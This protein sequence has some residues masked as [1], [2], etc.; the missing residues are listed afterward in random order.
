MNQMR[1]S[2]GGRQSLASCINAYVTERHVLDVFQTEGRP[3]VVPENRSHPDAELRGK[4]CIVLR[5]GK[6]ST[7]ICKSSRERSR[8]APSET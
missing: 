4:M 2:T 1:S 3:Q 5:R 7:S 8:C 6:L